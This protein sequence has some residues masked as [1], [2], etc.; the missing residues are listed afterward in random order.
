MHFVARCRIQVALA[1]AAL[2]VP[3][4]NLYAQDECQCSAPGAE[5]SRIANA[6]GGGLF[7]GLIAAVIPFHH[8][9]ALAAA[10]PGAGGGAPSAVTMMSDSTDI[11]PAD[12]AHPRRAGNYAAASPAAGD[13]GV[14]PPLARTSNGEAATPLPSITSDQAAADG[15]IAPRTATLLP[16]LA[17]IGIGSIIMGIFFLR[18]RR[19]RMRSR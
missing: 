4:T 15:M 19:P 18:I 17:M 3:A 13:P 10:A 7:A 9:A 1:V 8:A 12:S 6:I 16:A 14:G 5:S 11:A 2:V